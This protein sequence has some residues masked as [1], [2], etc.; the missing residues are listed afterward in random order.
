[1][2]ND[3]EVVRAL[4]DRGASPNITAMGLTPFLVAAGVGTGGRGAGGAGSAPNTQLMDLLLQ[5][6]ANVNVQVSGTK[7]YSMR[8]ARSPSPNEG[9]TALHVAVQSGRVEIVRYILDHGASTKLVDDNGRTPI[10]LIAGGAGLGARGAS[11]PP[12]GNPAANPAGARGSA[13]GPPPSGGGQRG[14]SG[15]NAAEIRDLLQN[16]P[17]NK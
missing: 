13:A 10:D 8:I 2:A 3:M 14:A 6:G 9:M 16:A 4:L 7:T 15:A 5:H 12:A 1:M 11:A 17:A